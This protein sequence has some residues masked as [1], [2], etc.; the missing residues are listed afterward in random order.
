MPKR[1]NSWLLGSSLVM[2]AVLVVLILFGNSDS[3]ISVDKNLFKVADQTKI[4][5]IVLKNQDEQ[6]ELHFDGA[7]WMVNDSFEAD[8]QLIQV[9]FATLLQTEPR[10]PAAQRLR[11]SIHQK[12]T[13]S[14]IEVKLFE[15]KDLAQ[16]RRQGQADPSAPGD[17]VG[18]GEVDEAEDAVDERVAQ[19]DQGIQAAQREGVDQD[20]E[21]AGHV[22]WV[23]ASGGVGEALARRW[24]GVGGAI[25]RRSRGLARPGRG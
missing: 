24:R 12:I 6:I 5:L 8:R 1:N 10:R 16:R 22:G 3:H 15:G 21:E 11:D 13:Q 7:R 14:G 25:A 17:D 19:R 20:L 18:V 4:D 9:V 2:I 23:I